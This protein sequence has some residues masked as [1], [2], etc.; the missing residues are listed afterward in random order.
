[1]DGDFVFGGESMASEVSGLININKNP[2]AYGYARVSHATGHQKNESVPAQKE[3]INDYY[4]LKLEPEGIAW[5][6]TFDDGTNISAYTT[7]FHARPAG[8]K[9]MGLIQ[10][11]DHIVLD[12]VDRIWRSMSDFVRL[13]ENLKAR[14]ITVHIVNF[15]G[16]SIQNDTAMGDFILRVFVLMSELESDLKSERTRQALDVLRR[17]GRRRC[18]YVPA[19]CKVEVSY[20]SEG[21]KISLLVWDHRERELMKYIVHLKDDLALEWDVVTPMVQQYVINTGRKFYKEPRIKEL[22]KYEKAY[23]YLKII[24]P[25][26]IPKKDIINEAARQARRLR[27]LKISPA[28]G[29]TIPVITREQ[30]LEFS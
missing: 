26:D 3:R 24:E 8:R 9:I 20:T 7:P 2:K 11:G 14:N 12:K 23:D 1:M 17:K 6:G 13:M 18:C 30:L 21:N 25:R 28:D 22:Y 16:S 4:K 27:S 10:P 19:G 29:S 5:C 15:L